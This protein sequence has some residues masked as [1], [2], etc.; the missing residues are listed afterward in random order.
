MSSTVNDVLSTLVPKLDISGANWVIFL[1]RF[2]IVIQGK[3][4]QRHFD[5]I[6]I[7]PVLTAIQATST[8]TAS[9]TIASTTTLPMQT[10]QPIP[11]SSLIGIQNKIS[12][13][14]QNESIAHSFLGQQLLDATLVLMLPTST[15]KSM[16]KAIIKEYVYKS[17]YSQAHLCCDFISSRCPKEG[18]VQ[19]FL[20]NLHA[21]KAKLATVSIKIDDNKYQ[22]VIIQSLLHWLVSFAS[23]QLISVSLVGNTMILDLLIT[24]ICNKQDYG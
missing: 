5:R 14:E 3:E 23:I 19:V 12:I 15:V 4:L 20:N 2:Q 21:K 22:N 9:T 7:C 1:L 16:W 10:S 13:Q 24:F 18:D 11:A 8:T 17:I 6:S